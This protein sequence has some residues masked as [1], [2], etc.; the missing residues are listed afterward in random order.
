VVDVLQRF[1]F[2]YDAENT[3]DKYNFPILMGYRPFVVER[4]F[5]PPKQ[6]KWE[7]NMP[8][9]QLQLLVYGQPIPLN[10]NPPPA[11]TYNVITLPSYYTNYGFT[12][13]VSGRLIVEALIIADILNITYDYFKD[14]NF[15]LNAEMF[16]AS[17]VEGPRARLL[18]ECSSAGRVVPVLSA[19]AVALQVSGSAGRVFG[20]QMICIPR[21]PNLV[22][23]DVRPSKNGLQVCACRRSLASLRA[24]SSIY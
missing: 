23:L 14:W 20:L 16:A 8:V 24:S 4:M 21:R 1:Y 5:N 2:A 7:N 22:V 18:A 3:Y 6:I 13:Q 19:S 17:E 11:S 9:G 12:L 15:L 10:T